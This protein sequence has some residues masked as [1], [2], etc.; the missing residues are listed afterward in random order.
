M[1]EKVNGGDGND[2][3]DIWRVNATAS[4]WACVVATQHEWCT[5]SGS[6]FKGLRKELKLQDSVDQEV[7]SRGRT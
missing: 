6:I 7:N 2:G 4:T 1:Y 5:S 3:G